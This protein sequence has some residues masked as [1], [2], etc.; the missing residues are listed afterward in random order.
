MSKTL[1][2]VSADGYISYWNAVTTKCITSARDVNQTDLFCVDFKKDGSQFAVGGRDYEVKIYDINVMSPVLSL[3][4]T[5]GVDMG[6]SNRVLSVHFTEDPNLL[7]SGGLDNTVFFW[8]LRQARAT[9]FIFGPHICGDSIATNGNTMLTGSYHNTEVLQ[10]WNIPERK[11]IETVQWEPGSE[12]KYEHGYVY[13]VGY[14]KMSDSKKYIAAGGAGENE[15]RVFKNTKDHE[16]VE[17]LKFKRAVTSV[18]FAEEKK[19]LAVACGDGFTR[20]YSYED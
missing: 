9:G 5:N 11:L 15:L 13:S 1:L 2:A 3:K 4:S 6:H 14:D 20:V 10:T 16:L 7:L 19:M 18:D 8:D 17:K 12:E